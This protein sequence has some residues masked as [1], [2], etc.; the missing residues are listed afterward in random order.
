MYNKLFK[1]CGFTEGLDHAVE[2]AKR[3][4]SPYT[5]G[6]FK[7]AEGFCKMMAWI[8]G[9][10]GALGLLTLGLFLYFKK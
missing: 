4:P 10:M 2:L 6:H 5:Q 3:Y 7:S 9:S 8:W 1:W